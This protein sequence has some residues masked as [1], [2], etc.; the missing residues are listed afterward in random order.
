MSYPNQGLS[1]SLFCMK[2]GPNRWLELP[3]SPMLCHDT[4]CL[5]T[6]PKQQLRD[7]GYDSKVTGSAAGRREGHIKC[8]N[9][10]PGSCLVLTGWPRAGC[11]WPDDL[12]AP[13]DN[14]FRR[15]LPPPALSWGPAAKAALQMLHTCKWIPF[16][17]Q[18]TR[19]RAFILQMRERGTIG[20][21][22]SPEV[23]LS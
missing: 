13:R 22:E 16:F 10:A 7:V 3:D 11:F 17:C 1:S 23:C 20:D 8:P 5:S 21:A 6:G 19:Q 12:A 14:C 9:E 15:C 4:G 2:R 18:Q